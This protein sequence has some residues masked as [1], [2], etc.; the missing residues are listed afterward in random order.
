VSHVLPTRARFVAD[1]HAP[2]YLKRRHRAARALLVRQITE[3]RQ[4]IQDAID[5]LS[6]VVSKP[7][8]AILLRVLGLT[9]AGLIGLWI[10]LV[11]LVDHFVTLPWG[12]AETALDVAAGAGFVVAMIFLVAPVSSLIAGLFLDEIA[13]KVEATAFPADPPGSALPLPQVLL[14]SVKFFGAVIL[15]NLLALVLLL[16]PGVNLVAFLLVNAYL[17]GR[18]YFEL[19][20]LRFRPYD[21]A[22]VLRRAHGGRIFGAGLLVA[23]F[24]MIPVVNLATPLFATAFMVRLH[25]RISR[26]G[27]RVP[28]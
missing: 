4:M 1:R 21:E 27:Q 16:L 14:S 7:F 25:K 8:R 17:L 24:V 10:V 11:W 6:D 9:L 20:A 2:A 13:A 26:E 19:A 15:A 22:R 12:W 28:A 18:E 3:R 5:A 23:L